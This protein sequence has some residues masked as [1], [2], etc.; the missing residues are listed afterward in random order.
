MS[1][2]PIEDAFERDEEKWS[3]LIGRFILEFANI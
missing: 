3:P 2:E 1:N